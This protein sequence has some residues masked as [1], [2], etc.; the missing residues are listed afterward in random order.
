MRQEEFEA[1]FSARWEQFESWLVT[2]GR[3]GKN[4]AGKGRDSGGKPVAAGPTLDAADVPRCYREICQHLALARDREYS[5]DLID[6]LSGL[7]LN[8]HHL[9]YSARGALWTRLGQFI[10]AGFPAQVRREARLVCLAAALF[11]GPLALLTVTLQRYPDF[12]YVMLDRQQVDSFEAMY[13]KQARTL[14]RKRDADSDVAMFG[15]YIYN[16]IG[17]G[18]QTFAGGVLFGLGTLFYLL[19]NGGYIGTIMGH[20]I[21]AGFAENF[22]S[23]TSGHSAFELLAIVLSG[24]A[25]LRLGI[26]LI[27]PGRRSRGEAL[28]RAA[29]SA[30]LLISGAAGM[31]L[32]AAGIEAFWSPLRSIP[33]MMKYGVGLALWC[34]LLAYFLFGGR[35]RPA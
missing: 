2:G 21:Q 25:G 3:R 8:G 29:R 23:F 6:R 31:F 1:L 17:I 33:P 30:S 26:S 27:A 5:A 34:V 4:G 7:A 15:F 22:F 14:G 32:V 28:R 35:G 9:L 11:F 13:G 19:F 16:N 18:F 20:V 12:A 10:V 24:A